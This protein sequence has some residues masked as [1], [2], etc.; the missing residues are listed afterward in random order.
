MPLPQALLN[1]LNKDEQEAVKLQARPD[2]T[3]AVATP[4]VRELAEKKLLSMTIKALDTVDAVMD[5]GDPKE[6]LAA[7]TTVIDRS[8]ATKQ[9]LNTQPVQASVPDAAIQ[10]L[11]T[12]LGK[13]FASMADFKPSEMKT[14]EQPKT[15]TLK[16]P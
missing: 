5:Y 16:E 6:R 7:A 3:A 4:V 8:P 14:V 11:M 10:S 2:T 15:R 13:L 12:G 1:R 9:L